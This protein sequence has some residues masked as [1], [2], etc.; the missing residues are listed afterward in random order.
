MST[1]A[2]RMSIRALLALPALL[3]VVAVIAMSFRHGL[4]GALI[5]VIALFWGVV[6]STS[7]A[8]LF[9][10]SGMLMAALAVIASLVLCIVSFFFYFR[11]WDL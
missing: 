1:S 8:W 7:G 3:G 4:V 6:A 11:A 5:G 2:Q 10:R 9:R